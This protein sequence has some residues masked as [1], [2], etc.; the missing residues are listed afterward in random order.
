MSTLPAGQGPGNILAIRLSADEPYPINPYNIAYRSGLRAFL[1][2]RTIYANVQTT[3]F[4]GNTLY[5]I[6]YDCGLFTTEDAF[7]F[8][9]KEFFN[10]PMPYDQL[11]QPPPSPSPTLYLTA[12][13]PP[14]PPQGE[15]THVMLDAGFQPGY[16]FWV[17]FAG[18]YFLTFNTIFRNWPPGG[19]VRT[20]PDYKGFQPSA[21]NPTGGAGSGSGSGGSGQ[22]C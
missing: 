19:V 21:N 2:V 13:P 15:E 1:G 11:V 5:M 22:N 10:K 12:T 4:V 14:V 3:T 18:N 6:H 9:L 7:K 20:G 17:T 16:G 8:F